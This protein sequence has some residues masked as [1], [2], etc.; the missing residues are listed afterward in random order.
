[1]RGKGRGGVILMALIFGLAMTMGSTSGALAAKT[2]VIGGIMPISGPISVVGMAWQ[3]GWELAADKIN[4]QG[5]LKVKGET[6]KV[7]FIIEDSKLSPDAAA[8]AARKLVHKDKARFV[9]G[10]ILDQCAQGIYNICAP[11]KV[12]HLISWI[13][14]PR[15][16]GD[17]SPQKPF[18]VRPCVSPDDAV[19]NDYVYL[20]KAFPEV[21]TVVMSAPGIGY[22][23]MIED[24]KIKAK[25][26]GVEVV[27]V[28]EWQFGIT[29]FLPTY[30]K[31]LALKPD[32]I[33]CMVSA[34][35]MYQLKAARQLGFEGVFFSDSPLGPDVMLAVA[36]A[37]FCDKVFC[38]GMH[39]GA[40]TPAMTAVMKAWQAKYKEPFI[41]DA[42]LA[43]DEMWM[44]AQVIEKCGSVDPSE[45]RET[46]DAATAPGS[47]KSVFGE[48]HMGGA[49]RFGVNR[50]L[51]RPIPISKISK[52]EAELVGLFLPNSFK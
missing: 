11:A 51:V 52:G 45:V 37:R 12:L 47:L 19:M 26:V 20:K 30:T 4:D 10:A 14:V 17:V 9:L 43:F 36:G 50:V 7:K 6:Y 23:P 32:A 16:P 44:L 25:K 13:N 42:L 5:G 18:A 1:M 38:N 29:D 41:S 21:K 48:S 31:I 3:R 24:N 46:F 39:L 27:G 40:A 34:Q 33:H 2:L 35:A 15:V 8:Q 49:E 22:G 28:E